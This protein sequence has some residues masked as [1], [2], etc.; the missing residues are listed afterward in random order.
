[1]QVTKQM[2]RENIFCASGEIRSSYVTAEKNAST[3]TG[4]TYFLAGKQC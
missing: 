2:Q 3:K 4:Y 1:M